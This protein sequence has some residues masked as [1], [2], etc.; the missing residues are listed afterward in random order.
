MFDKITTIETLEKFLEKKV[1]TFESTLAD[2]DEKRE[3]DA[4]RDDPYVGNTHQWLAWH[5][6]D[7]IQDAT[8]AKLA[9][10]I[11]SDLKH[12]RRFKESDNTEAEI[13]ELI[14]RDVVS[15]LAGLHER[16][17]GASTSHASNLCDESASH[18]RIE[19]LG[20]LTPHGF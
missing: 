12:Q 7:M 17:G 16:V 6:V 8:A 9:Q 3:Q 14:R 2:F 15:R 19:L 20:A 4:A 10:G 11:L 1:T 18:F 13:L 5:A